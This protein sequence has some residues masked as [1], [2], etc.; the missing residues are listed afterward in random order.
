ML[1]ARILAIFGGVLGFLMGLLLQD[2][3]ATRDPRIIKG[4]G[5]LWWFVSDSM[6]GVV[7]TQPQLLRVVLVSIPL[8]SVLGAI[9]VGVRPHLG[10]AL[11]FASA[12][13]MACTMML[14][15]IPNVAL[16]ILSASAGFS[17]LNA[18]RN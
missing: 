4:A 1:K 7:T 17:A 5:P 13:G 14:P 9:V 6:L 18:R 11:M 8:L 10:A 12:I 16:P 2:L 3:V 15:V